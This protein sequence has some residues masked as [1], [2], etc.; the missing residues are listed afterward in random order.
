[1]DA[2]YKTLLLASLVSSCSSVYMDVVQV[3]QLMPAVL[4]IP[5]DIHRV[6]V[7]DR[8]NLT[9]SDQEANVLAYD[10]YEL[11]EELGVQLSNSQYFQDVILC[12]SDVS[13]LDRE[14]YKI[15]PLSQQHVQELAEDLDVDMLVTV[16]S[17]QAQLLP[18]Y[19]IPTAAINAVAKVYVPQRPR[20]LHTIHVRDTLTWQEGAY[21]NL[22][23]KQVKQDAMVI[24]C[25]KIANQLAPFWAPVQRACFKGGS[26]EMRDGAVM[27]ERG[28]WE[29]A[30]RE[31]LQYKAKAKGK[32]LWM[33]QF[34]LALALEMQ[35][36]TDAALEACRALRKQAAPSVAH[37]Q[38]LSD[39]MQVLRQRQ[40]MVQTLKLQMKR[41]EQ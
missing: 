2:V 41:H 34:N 10:T 18:S 11:T 13:H 4:S 7:V 27:A 30:Q 14:E 15:Y 9:P 31:W 19:V 32:N 23:V 38:V 28:E 26:P 24:T 22:S 12:D 21:L 39:Y 5:Q 6:A 29:K 16:E 37:T 3:E 36:D 17:A 40:T 8:L 33:V 20:A 25:E 1:M 35:G